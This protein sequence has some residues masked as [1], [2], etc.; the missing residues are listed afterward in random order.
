MNTPGHYTDFVLLPEDKYLLGGFDANFMFSFMRMNSDGSI[1]TGFGTNG[2]L[3]T[4]EVGKISKLLLH[5]NLFIVAIACD[6][7]SDANGYA[8][9]IDSYDLDIVLSDALGSGIRLYNNPNYCYEIMDLAI[10]PNGKL[11]VDGELSFYTTFGC[12]APVPGIVETS[13]TEICEEQDIVLT[14][15]GGQL[16]DGTMWKWFAGSCEGVEIGTGNS[17]T[18]S[19]S[20]STN[21]FVKGLGG[22]VDD[23]QCASVE[24]V[25]H[26]PV[27]NVII[28]NDHFISIGIAT[29][30]QWLSC[31]DMTPVTGA[32][33]SVYY[34]G[35]FEQYALQAIS[36]TCTDISDCVQI[37]QICY[38]GDFDCDGIVGVTDLVIFNGQ[39][40]C[41]SNCFADL[42][43]DGVV[44]IPDLISFFGLFGTI[45]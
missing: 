27:A 40:F 1:D 21:Y 7:D 45:Y 16:N 17:I 37:T 30:Y 11:L 43:G 2:I 24:V 29:S 4:G 15:V 36:G 3:G 6:G 12:E 28:E 42:N 25:L 38:P 22:C 44:S 9:H 13:A 33:N 20:E 26:A 35:D 31:S 8:V 23:S 39:M 32:T 34:P 18:V 19:P 41:T 10:M 14:Q 5:D